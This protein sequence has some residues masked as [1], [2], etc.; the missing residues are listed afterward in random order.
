MRL[1]EMRPV[2]RK[3]IMD[4]ETVLVD[5]TSAAHWYWQDT[6][7]DKW[8]LARDFH[9]LTPPA[10][11]TYMEYTMPRLQNVDGVLTAIHPAARLPIGCILM[12]KGLN[13]NDRETDVLHHYLSGT[14]RITGNTSD[15][16]KREMKERSEKRKNEI[17]NQH[18]RFLLLAHLFTSH[19]S[20]DEHGGRGSGSICDMFIYL[21]EQGKAYDNGWGMA[22]LSTHEDIHAMTATFYPF[23]LALS[24]MNC[25]NVELV[26]D[27]RH[28]SR[29]ERRRAN[30]EGVPLISYKWLQIKQLQRRVD[31]DASSSGE[32]NTKRL[33]FVRAH[34]ATYTADAPLFG[35]YQG[36]YFKPQHVRGNIE[37]GTVIKGYS[38]DAPQPETTRHRH[39]DEFVI[40]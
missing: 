10:K 2:L 13:D 9:A 26:D 5:I 19:G 27:Q 29:N 32:H 12:C 14:A 30:R 33:H 8:D 6:P 24:L 34:W 25:K 36:T 18:P 1:L 3:K 17:E 35:K 37:A 22:A 23:A 16:L 38:V 20:F 40:D 21:D 11:K 15:D 28:V 4:G 39:T 31:S 7:Q